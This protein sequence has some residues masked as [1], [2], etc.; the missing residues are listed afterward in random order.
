MLLNI[1]IKQLLDEFLLLPNFCT[2]LLSIGICITSDTSILDIES[3]R[4][5]MCWI[6]T[7]KV[8]LE[9]DYC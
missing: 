1:S 7:L 5:K 4:T 3:K 8:N 2:I 6:L 9:N